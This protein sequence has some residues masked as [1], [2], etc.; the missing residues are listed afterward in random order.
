MLFI[1][2]HSINL[3]KQKTEKQMCQKHAV[4][5]ELFCKVAS[6]NK[7]NTPKH[8]STFQFGKSVLPALYRCKKATGNGQKLRNRKF[9]LTGETQ[10]LTQFGVIL[11]QEIPLSGIHICN[12]YNKHCHKSLLKKTEFSIHKSMLTYLYPLHFSAILEELLP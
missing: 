5:T 2:K 10:L 8:S 11:Q 3:N 12:N 6:I 1:S 9:S 4:E 7:Q